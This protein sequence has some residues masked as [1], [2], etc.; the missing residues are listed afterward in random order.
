MVVDLKD[1]FADIFRG[2]PVYNL[3]YD[4]RI[5]L[6]SSTVSRPA[7]VYC[8]LVV[9]ALINQ[10][11]FFEHMACV[12]KEKKRKYLTR[13]GPKARRVLV[14]FQASIPGGG[15][16]AVMLCAPPSPPP[17]QYRKISQ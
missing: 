15:G 17:A 3:Y 11:T 4:Q 1:G 8:S 13:A 16:G 2:S 12:T 14:K 9:F 7:R 10:P 5:A 6:L